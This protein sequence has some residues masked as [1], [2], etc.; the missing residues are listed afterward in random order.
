MSET[1][2]ARPI[3]P[4]RRSILGG[5]TA[6]A[7][8]PFAL[9]AC[10]APDPA[11]QASQAAPTG[12]DAIL[13]AHIPQTAVT[14]DIAGEN[15]STPG[16]L[17]YPA[18][19]PQTVDAP[20]GSGGSYSAM[21]PSWS[22]VQSDPSNAF[23]AALDEAFGATLSYQMT[24]GNDYRDKQAAVFA[25]PADVADWVSVF[26]WNPPARFDQAVEAVFQDLTP[27]LAGD[28]V[29]EWKN[30]AN[31]P[32]A[33]WQ[34]GVFNGKLYGIPVP[35]EIVTDGIFVRPDLLEA[36]GVE[37]PRTAE[38][39][40]TV[41]AALTDPAASR[42]ASN[43]M[44]TGA[45]NLLFGAPPDWRETSDGAL[46]Y[47]WE[48]VEYRAALEFQIELFEK[49]Y[50]HPDV[51]AGSGDAK[52]R[53]ESG[54]VAIHYDGVGAWADMR[55]R[56]AAANP[57]ASVA[58]LTQLSAQGSE[59]LRYAG[60]PANFFSFL[61][62]SDDEARIRELL[63]IAN[64]LAA[65]FGT[66]E[67]ELAGYG[68]EGVHFTRGADGVPVPTDALKAEHPGVLSTLVTGPVAKYDFGDPDFVREY[69]AWMAGE[70][71]HMVEGPF[72]GYKIIRPLE[73]AAL[74]QPLYDL[75]KDV[76]RGRK[77]M[78]DFDQAVTNWKNAG[79]DR[80]REYY[81]QVLAQLRDADGS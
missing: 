33:A 10:S 29:S 53:F 57:A 22:A 8:G 42:W 45:P 64:I 59:S 63:G 2:P 17:S 36:A 47:R 11:Q 12:L 35:G 21:V 24:T 26:A 71:A 65:P 13:P 79:G 39:F 31:L 75:E 5:L 52:Q 74:D 14:P 70:T 78:A 28:K 81:Q 73:Y 30:L 37:A 20:P 15:G 16:Y 60:A 6:A 40:L 58:P 44:A 61:K 18:E 50:V 67:W 56:I 72:H 76:A 1:R 43:D 19:L 23:T 4:S 68:V 41:C 48:T 32:T 9:A 49:G 46:E 38:E 51:V 34:Y 7:V 66:K 55:R 77:T 3:V 27:Y 25:S 54:Q 69:C 80:M 62:K